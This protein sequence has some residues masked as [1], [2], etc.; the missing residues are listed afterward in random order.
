M[1]HT[2]NEGTEEYNQKLSEKRSNAVK[3]YLVEKGINESQ[4]QTVGYGKIRPAVS[5]DTTEGRGQNRRVEFKAV[6]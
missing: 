4:I 5:N 1:G 3:E 2:D 6:W